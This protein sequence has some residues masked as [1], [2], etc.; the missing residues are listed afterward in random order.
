MV[1]IVLMVVK[2]VANS[3]MSFVVGGS[4]FLV[5]VALQKDRC[6][7][8]DVHITLSAHRRRAEPL[9]AVMLYP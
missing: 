5:V 4:E 1:A 8:S 3:A 2:R 6:D 9:S 7:Q